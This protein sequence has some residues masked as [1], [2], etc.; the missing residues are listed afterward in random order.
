MSASGSAE[1]VVVALRSR[2]DGDVVGPEDDEY[3]AARAVWNGM[4]DKRPGA[5]ARCRTNE[6]VAGAV[7]VARERGLPLAVRGGGH[8]VAGT[9]TSEGGVVIDL[10]AM[11]E[12]RVDPE[13]H[14]A[15]VQGGAI[16]REVDAATQPY[17][18]AAPAGLVSE[19][20]V[21][22][23][24]LGGGIG[25]LRRKYG[26]SCDNLIGAELVTARGELVR[27]A[28]DENPELL[29]ALRGGGGNFGVVTS[30]EFRLYP[31]GPEVAYALVLYDGGETRE[32]L[33][34]FR[35]AV[36]GM[37]REISPIAFTGAVPEGMAGVPAE[38]AGKPMVAVAAAYVGPPEEGEGELTA[39]RGLATPI[40]DL[41]GRMPYAVLQQ[42]LDEDYPRGRH[43]YWKS[44]ALDEL[45]DEVVDIV[46]EY[47]ASQPSP[48]STIDIWLMGGAIAEEPPGGSAYSG[49]S[50][51]YLVNPE[52]DW[53]DPAN[54]DE[55]VAWARRFIEALRPYSVGNYLNFPGLL[56]EGE[57]QLRASFGPHFER[58][59]D[60]KTAWD[61][62]N[63]FRLNHNVPPRRRRRAA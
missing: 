49:R 26:L 57:A 63:V 44:A 27:A 38:A 43:Y 9:A 15:T 33:R 12:V 61:P 41:S 28:L 46:A 39:L 47:A 62:D 7:Q 60:V 20:G 50:A 17:G 32:V 22:G 31:V 4:I 30:F 2:L 10:A 36:A 45:S 54:D 29:W 55:N 19:T 59:V 21:A 51:G 11:N 3:G 14:L 37:R 52:A 53:D 42:F 6:D 18:L 35:E 25:W 8:N 5:I 1:D 24:T 56:E 13:R 23:L 48:I 40:A 34:S 58:L 16:W